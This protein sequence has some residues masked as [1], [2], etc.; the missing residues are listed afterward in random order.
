MTA[1]AP[2]SAPAAG[3]AAS[4][5][6]AAHKFPALS[7]LLHWT[8]A[9]MI[10]AMLFIGIG[11]V[12]SPDRYHRLISIHRPLGAAILVLAAVRLINRQ[13]N[14]PPP[15]PAGMPGALKLAASASH[16]ALY[17]LM[18]AVPLAGWATLSAGAYPVLLFGGVA[19]PPIAPHNAALYAALRETHAVLALS[20]FAVFL[21]HIAAA[22]SHALI[23]RDGVFQSMAGGR[24]P[25][26]TVH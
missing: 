7:R 26:P 12:A 8:M 23:Y 19:L 21:L 4:A 16:V 15:L 6:V 3:Q 22:L 25:D 13:I 20:L 9:A 11:M 24:T 18:F 10:L 17:V 5:A 1:T 2:A 14:R